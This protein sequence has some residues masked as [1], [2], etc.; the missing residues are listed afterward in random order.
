[1]DRERIVQEQA[2]SGLGV[3]EF[4]RKHGIKANNFYNWRANLKKDIPR[5]ARVASER[6]V[7]IELEGGLRLK[8]AVEDLKAVLLELR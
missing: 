2:A 5:F 8:V 1:M 3:V 6:L 4:C 7:E